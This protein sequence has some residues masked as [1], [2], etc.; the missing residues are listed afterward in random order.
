[1]S[2]EAL[3]PLEFHLFD[4]ESSRLRL[5]LKN[6]EE[7]SNMKLQTTLGKCG[8]EYIIRK[9]LIDP[10][11]LTLID[12]QEAAIGALYNLVE[13]LVRIS[14]V[15]SLGE[16]SVTTGFGNGY[17][18]LGSTGALQR[19]SLGSGSSNTKSSQQNGTKKPR[20]SELRFDE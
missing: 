10:I 20:F 9:R 14:R 16:N 4:H 11:S 18:V 1:M 15:R 12:A 13:D 2:Q 5:G 3:Q 6:H 17:H 8:E 7:S 19:P